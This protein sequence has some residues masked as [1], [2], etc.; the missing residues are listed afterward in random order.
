MELRGIR[1]RL[2]GVEGEP[3][4]L[5]PRNQVGRTGLHLQTWNDGWQWNNQFPGRVGTH[6][7]DIV[8]SPAMDSV[9]TLRLSSGA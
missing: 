4:R 2:A 1:T 5:S 7:I 3:L 8:D 6:S 9:T